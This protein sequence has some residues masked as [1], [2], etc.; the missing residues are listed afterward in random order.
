MLNFEKTERRVLKKRLLAAGWSIDKNAEENR[1]GQKH[2]WTP[3]AHRKFTA[4]WTLRN[5][6][7]TAG[8]A[9]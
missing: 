4:R 8:I 7:R 9:K 1:S 5:A 3:V 6:C 2:Q